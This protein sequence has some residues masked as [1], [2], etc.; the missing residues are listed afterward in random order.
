[1]PKETHFESFQEHT[2]LKHLVLKSYLQ[3]W[4]TILLRNFPRV[5]FVDAFA[6]T[7]RD[8]DGAPGSPI[9]AAQIA[10]RVNSRADGPPRMRVFAIEQNARRYDALVDALAPY[11]GKAKSRFVFHSSG[12]LADRIDSFA[13]R[14]TE[15]TLLFLDPFGIAGLERD[16]LVKA[17]KGD[18]NELLILFSDE[19]AVRLHGKVAAR[20]PTREDKLASLTTPSLLGADFDAEQEAVAREAVENCLRGH[21]SSQQATLILERAFGGKWWQAI[22]EATPRDQRQRKFVD[23]Y[24]RVLEESGALHVLSFSVDTKEG[25]HKYFLLHASK[26]RRAYA[27]MKD[28]ISRARRQHGELR[29]Q[30]LDPEFEVTTDMESAATKLA[31]HF[32]GRQVRWQSKECGTETVREYVLDYTPVFPHELDALK[33]VLTRRSWRAEDRPLAF[34]FPK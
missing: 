27:A 7:G 19:G 9:I 4:A 10:Q 8:R 2:R 25:R 14:I 31:Q 13:C 5:L 32:A 28:A 11:T 30:S 29:Q 6:G 34:A 18:H 26:S 17:L 33:A 3:Q 12:T 24:K 23:L 22:I 16:V 21:Q 1:V 20:Q 15:P